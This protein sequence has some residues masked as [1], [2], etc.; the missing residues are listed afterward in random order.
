M[1]QKQ[2]IA[3][4]FYIR[5]AKSTRSKMAP[6]YMRIT[7]NGQRA[8]ISLQ[9]DVEVNK[10][11]PAAGMVT[12][13]SEAAKS[14][15][16]YITYWRQRTYDAQESLIKDGRLATAAAI[17]LLL[18]GGSANQKT[19]MEVFTFHNDRLL[20]RVGI[21]HSPATHVRYQ[22]T[23][24][25][26]LE[27]MQAKYGTSDIYLSHLGNG[28]AADFYHYLITIRK[29]NP[30]T[31]AKYVKNLKRITRY[32]MLNEWIT[33]DP[34]MGFSPAVKPVERGFL[35]M[36]ELELIEAKKMVSPRLEQV[37]DLF[38][39]ACYTGLAYIDVANLKP[40]NISK[41]INGSLWINTHRQK[42]NVPSNIPLLA[43][44]AE[45]IEKYHNHPQAVTSDRL[46]PV[47]SNQKLNA[48][49]KEIGDVCGITKN[50]TFHLARHT[51]ATTITLTNGVSIESV[52]AML[53]HTNIKTTQI[54][55][56]V[57]QKK[58]AEDMEN[59]ARKLSAHSSNEIVK[60]SNQ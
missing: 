5:K 31:S 22:T 39:F 2:S 56:K 16:Q 49:L 26:V 29:C 40:E 50:L 9:R 45:I 53:G 27:F 58:V 59:L 25:H 1:T 51:F 38:I 4:L 17:K 43:K 32:A 36:E 10:W 3:V 33:R 6:I 37:K 57:V 18:T 47:L 48:Y 12:G 34:F 19:L 20:E 41:G 23:K 14:L 21:D 11:N 8:E 46:L 55:A 7:V 52:S 60:K 54:Y 30:N 42:T 24:G 28:F 13:S 44:A 35:T 15:N